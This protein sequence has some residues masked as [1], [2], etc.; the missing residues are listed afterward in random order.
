MAVAFGIPNQGGNVQG[1]EW[2]WTPSVYTAAATE[3]LDVFATT[4]EL[5][6]FMV[7]TGG[8]AI[9]TSLFIANSAD[10][11]PELDIYFLNAN[12]SLGTEGSAVAL[13][14]GTIIDD[15]IGK[16]NVPTTAW[17]DLGTDHIAQLTTKDFGALQLQAASGQTSIWAGIIIQTAVT[18]VASALTIR[19][20]YTLL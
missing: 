2:L 11:E 16:I 17:E 1:V 6:G 14:D 8:A 7:Q 9:I 4:E 15:M 5:A 10:N 18:A 13:T 3:V 20:N 19:I 12:S